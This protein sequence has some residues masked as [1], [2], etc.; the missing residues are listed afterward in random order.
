MGTIL[1]VFA[2]VLLVIEAFR[3]TAWSW[4]FPHLGWLG[5]ALCV[6]A[7]ILNNVGMR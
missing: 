2:F 4:P 7:F 1:L 6:L 3:P 5:L